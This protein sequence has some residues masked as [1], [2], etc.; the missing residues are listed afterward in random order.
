M[1]FHWTKFPAKLGVPAK[2]GLANHR[3]CYSRLSAADSHSVIDR[4]HTLENE[5]LTATL[6][7]F[8]VINGGDSNCLCLF[9]TEAANLLLNLWI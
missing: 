9:L 4:S 6:G 1:L 3:A 7:L 2:L 5:V 8:E